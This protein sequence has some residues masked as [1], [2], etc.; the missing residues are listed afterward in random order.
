MLPLHQPPIC[1]LL[2]TWTP[3]AALPPYGLLMHNTSTIRSLRYFVLIYSP[4]V[5]KEH[6]EYTNYF[7][8]S[9]IFLQLFL[10]FFLSSSVSPPFYWLC[11][12]SYS[13]IVPFLTLLAL[14]R[15]IFFLRAL[16]FAVTICFNVPFIDFWIVF[17][18]LFF[19]IK[20][21]LSSFC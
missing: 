7:W 3:V 9:Q 12:L 20:K 11:F 21:P 14:Y 5:F 6:C 19:A 15:K 4:S 16:R 13:K 17:L 1:G 18:L 10:F 8:I 2:W